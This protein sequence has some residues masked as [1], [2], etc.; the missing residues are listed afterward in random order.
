MQQEEEN[1][2]NDLSDTIWN[3]YNLI[4]RLK[5]IRNDAKNY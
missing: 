1:T 3:T 2:Y 5:G 4:D